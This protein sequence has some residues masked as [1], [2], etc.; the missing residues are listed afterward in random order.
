M[1]SYLQHWFLTDIL[2]LLVNQLRSEVNK[3]LESART[4]KLIGASLDAKVYLHAENPD[5][6]SKLK[7]LASATNDADALH[8]LFITSQVEHLSFLKIRG[9]LSAFN[10]VL[11][12]P[13]LS[14]CRWRFSHPWVKK[15]HQVCPTRES[16]ATHARGRSGSVWLVRMAWN[17][18]AA[19][20]TPRTLGRSLTILRYARGATASLICNHKHLLPPPPSLEERRPGSNLHFI[21]NIVGG[22]HRL[23]VPRRK[24]W[25]LYWTK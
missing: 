3:I 19:G 21:V 8:R 23:F 4:G 22:I 25:P 16:S 5:T 20:F 18:S 9:P 14:F 1:S 17:A 2:H 15:P 6:V 11:T 7:E 13:L 10:F 24:L 12:S